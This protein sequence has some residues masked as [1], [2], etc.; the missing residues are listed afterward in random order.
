MKRSDLTTEILDLDEELAPRHLFLYEMQ[1]GSKTDLTEDL[2]LEDANPSFSPQGGVVAFGRKSLL[3]EEWTPGRQLW[4]LDR[5]AGDASAL[6]DDVDYHHSAFA[7]HPDGGQLAYV[8]YNQ[9]QLAEAPEIWLMDIDDLQRVR[10]V[11]NA[12]APRWIP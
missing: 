5:S 8:R 2:Y 11:I 4:L 10:L 6:T 7:W 3:S 12:F 1:D 9:A